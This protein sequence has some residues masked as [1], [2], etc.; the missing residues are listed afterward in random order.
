[1]H[2]MYDQLLEKEVAVKFIN[3]RQKNGNA[4]AHLM[5]KEV[6]ALSKL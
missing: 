6:E 5:K 1:M 3:F 2:L 4:N